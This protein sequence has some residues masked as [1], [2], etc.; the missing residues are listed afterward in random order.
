VVLALRVSG[1]IRSVLHT[2]CQ[3]AAGTRES[4][5]ICVR[6]LQS[7][8]CHVLFR[9]TLAIKNSGIVEISTRKLGKKMIITCMAAKEDKKSLHCWS[10]YLSFEVTFRISAT[11]QLVS[12]TC[13][14]IMIFN[15]LI[16]VQIF[17]IFI[18]EPC[19][20]LVWNLM[21]KTPVWIKNIIKCLLHMCAYV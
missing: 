14:K 7:L 16:E 4:C 8:T 19:H 2:C 13:Y 20:G 12:S 9:C 6:K 11:K 5:N 21:N 18:Y 10:K 15:T 3:E 17:A 1:Q